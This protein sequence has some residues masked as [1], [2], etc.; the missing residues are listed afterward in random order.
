MGCLDIAASNFDDTA[1]SH[2]ETLCQY[3]GTAGPEA[4]TDDDACLQGKSGWG[5]G[6]TCSGSTQYCFGRYADDMV[7]CPESC[8]KCVSSS[9]REILE[10]SPV[11]YFFR[12]FGCYTQC[13][14]GNGLPDPVAALY[15]NCPVFNTEKTGVLQG[16][17]YGIDEHREQEYI[18]H[19]CRCPDCECPSP[20]ASPTAAPS[21]APTPNPTFPL[22]P[23]PST[24]AL[25]EDRSGAG[26]LGAV[27]AVPL[28]VF[29]TWP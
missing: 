16:S 29:V 27:V 28:A 1:S 18:T 23:E 8:L 10:V 5:S 24:S 19:C 21:S 25:V 15:V 26:A 9:D 20:T 17:L 13:L 22:P 6:Y 7:C 3:P 2:D 14:E 12:P 11:S 4:C